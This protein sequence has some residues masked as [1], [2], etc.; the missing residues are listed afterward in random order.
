MRLFASIIPALL[1]LCCASAARVSLA[2][3][4]GHALQHLLD[5]SQSGRWAMNSTDGAPA[6][7]PYIADT[8]YYGS[9]GPA[10]AFVQAAQSGCYDDT[11]STRL[12]AAAD[13]ALAVAAGVNRSQ[14]GANTGLYY[15]Q[16]GI[17]YAL[18]ALTAGDG[19]SDR[20]HSST[21]AAAKAAA[22]DAIRDID[23]TILA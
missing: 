7:Y 11:F 18:R 2:A 21:A 22:R 3:A 12:R 14:F 5:T 10:I 15:G 8:V 17:A 1:L 13:E 6:Q 4:A 20:A 16:A 9:G 23:D 19:G